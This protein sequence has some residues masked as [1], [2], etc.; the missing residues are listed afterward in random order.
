MKR[1]WIVSSFAAATMLAGSLLVVGCGPKDAYCPHTGGTSDVCPI[2][3]DD[4]SLPQQDS[5]GGGE[6]PCPEGGTLHVG[7]DGSYCA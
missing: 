1:F 7:S 6:N 3:G 2:Q 4:K 5:G